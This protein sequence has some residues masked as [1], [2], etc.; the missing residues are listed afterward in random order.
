MSCN[1]S[2]DT[3]NLV[4]VRAGRNS[5][6]PHWTAGPGQAAFDL[7]VVPFDRAAPPPPEGRSSIFIP[8]RKIEGYNRLFHSH[9]D[10]LD[11]YDY[12]ALVDDDIL[13][14]KAA[15]SRL[16]EI[17]RSH[18]LDLFQPTLSWDSY[19][20]YA[21]TLTNPAYRL[22]Y[23]NIVEM[24]C[25]VFSRAHLVRALPLFAMGYELGIDLVWTKLTSEPWFRY[26]L[27]DEVVARHT[28][29]VGSSKVQHLPRDGGAYD[30]EIPAVLSKFETDFRGFVTY[31]AIDRDG[32]LVRSRAAIALRS[33]ALWR[34]WRA[35]PMQKLHFVRF[36]TDYHRHCLWRP[37]NLDRVDL[38][39]GRL[40][41]DAAMRTLPSVRRRPLTA[42]IGA[43]PAAEQPQTTG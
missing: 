22:R 23:T 32:R 39:G 1:S 26:A 24:M 3:K 10:L 21:A 25:P 43:S 34:A 5:L 28:R 11:R 40:A 20:S 19:F 18:R 8:G 41:G 33:R 36:L 42:A 17:G 16:F 15:L 38:N 2:L 37:L 12:I 14:S 6:H 7:L 4:V 31:A 27:I 35:T 9:A 30:D 13:I 29:P